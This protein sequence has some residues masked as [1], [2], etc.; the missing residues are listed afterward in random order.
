[1]PAGPLRETL[2]SIKRA[3][4]IVINGK[5][6]SK[7]E[8]EIYKKNTNIKIYY[9]KF[10]LLNNN[11]FKDKKVI[12][13][14]GIAN[15]SNF[16]DLLEENQIKLINKISFPDHYKFLKKDLDELIHESN[17]Q[18]AILVT[19]EKDYCRI[20]EDYKNNIE[21]IKVELEISNKNSFVELLKKNV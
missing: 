11:K 20:N 13:F 6:D 21:C 3:H 10:K 16:F 18:N 4:C 8:E 15:T 17:N 7:I 9:S 19:T 2:S 12:A 5:K 1:M 14:A